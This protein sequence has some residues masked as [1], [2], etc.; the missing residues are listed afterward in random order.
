VIH[1]WEGKIFTCH[2]CLSPVVEIIVNS[3]KAKVLF[4]DTLVNFSSVFCLKDL[5]MLTINDFIY[6]QKCMEFLDCYKDDIVAVCRAIS[7]GRF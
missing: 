6:H 3:V 2:R 4:L 5:Q 7:T 1:G